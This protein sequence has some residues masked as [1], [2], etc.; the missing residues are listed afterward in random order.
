MFS[1]RLQL[2]F[3]QLSG[4]SSLC[5]LEKRSKPSLSPLY[6]GPYLVI[7]RRSKFFRLQIGARID[8]VSL[9]RLKPVFSDSPVIPAAPPPRGRPPLC[10]SKDPPDPSSTAKSS[11]S[12]KSV[13]FLT[14]PVIIPRRNP[15]RQVRKEA[16][17]PPCLRH[18]FLGGVLWRKT[19]QYEESEAGYSDA[20]R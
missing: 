20:A 1:I 19:L 9:D 5:S 18:A 10:Q 2:R 8:S 16:L 15:H 12:K 6:C 11:A 3:L 7:E 14:Q 17:A 4:P 13:L